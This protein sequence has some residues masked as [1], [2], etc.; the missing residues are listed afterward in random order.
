[1][2]QANIPNITSTIDITREEAITL[3]IASIAMEELGLSHI[4]NAEGEKLQYVLGTLPGVSLAVPPTIGDL[5]AVNDSIR[6]TLKETVKKDWVLSNKL[7][8]VLC[9]AKKPVAP[10][11]PTCVPF[12][13]TTEFPLCG[14]TVVGPV[15]TCV[16]INY[17]SPI[18][19]VPLQLPSGATCVPVPPAGC[20]LSAGPSGVTCISR[21]VAEEVLLTAPRC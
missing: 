8:M 7:D 14:P 16:P 12:M 15:I 18:P 10:I 21:T 17:N 20:V 1:M 9:D 4:L 19:C 6:K 5:L 2:S 3:I 13:Y 11:G